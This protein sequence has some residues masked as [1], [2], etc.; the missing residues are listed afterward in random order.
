MFM[1]RSFILC[2]V[3]LQAGVPEQ[4]EASWRVSR[5]AVYW[6]I[7]LTRRG[8]ERSCRSTGKPFS[9]SRRN[10]WER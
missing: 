7:C 8:G 9:G 10:Y 3:D 4:M 5:K 2:L 6:V 1:M